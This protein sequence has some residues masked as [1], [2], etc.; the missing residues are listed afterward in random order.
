LLQYLFLDGLWLVIY[1]ILTRQ[2]Y[3]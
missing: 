1:F 2:N 3:L